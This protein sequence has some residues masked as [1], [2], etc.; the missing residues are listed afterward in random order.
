M[1][2]WRYHLRGGSGALAA[3]RV[4]G[5]LVAALLMLM[6]AA[7]GASAE[8]GEASR[9]PS[10]AQRHAAA[11][12][13][14]ATPPAPCGGAAAQ[15]RASAAGFVARRIYGREVSSPEVRR[16]Q[17]QVE[18]YRP[19]LSALASGNRSAVREAV[20][21]LVFSHTHVVRLRVSQGGSLLA[22]VGGPFILAPVGGSLRF[23]GRTVGHY[24]LSVQ[25]DS[26]YAKLETRYIGYP[27]LMR[28]GPRRLPVEGTFS[29]GAVSIPDGGPVSWR[30]ASYHVFSFPAHAYPSG[31]LKVSMLV[32]P[33]PSS[34]VPCATIRL[35]ELNRIAQRIWRR[36][37][38]VGGPVSGFVSTMG[39]LL[40]ALSYVRSPSH[41]LS[42]ATSPGPP[43]LPAAGTVRYRGAS[44]DV[45]SF[46]ATSGGARVRVYQLVR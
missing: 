1:T 29:P 19:L 39:S 28:Q 35:A 2:G 4:S 13:A 27:L 12:A 23:A 46:A 40:G 36:F 32:P 21:S 7:C 5:Y 26:G 15:T 10:P 33:P 45:F 41:Q 38:L 30:G 18:G 22:D 16:D 11:P 43:R 31:P 8:T 6:L 37:T 44:Y 42:G 3:G 20:T 24:L 9:N 25:D 34:T 14:I 17:R